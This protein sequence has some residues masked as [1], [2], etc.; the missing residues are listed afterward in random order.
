MAANGRRE[1]ASVDAGSACERRYDGRVLRMPD[2]SSD[3]GTETTRI[4]WEQPLLVR[5]E[6]FRESHRFQSLSPLGIVSAHCG[7]RS[8][9]DVSTLL[10]LLL[11]TI[12]S[13]FSAGGR[14][15]AGGSFIRNLFSFPQG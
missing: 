6:I 1:R 13:S 3:P 5:S 10:I 8:Q 2:A 9:P 4:R 14:N 11:K 7:Q 15:K 12:N